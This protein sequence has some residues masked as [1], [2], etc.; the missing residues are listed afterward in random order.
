VNT[1]DGNDYQSTYDTLL[2]CPSI[3]SIYYEVKSQG[4][5]DPEQTLYGI[6]FYNDVTG[7]A[8]TSRN[9]RYILTETWQYTSPYI[10]QY[11]WWGGPVIPVSRDTIYTCYMSDSVPELFSASTSSLS[12]NILKHNS[13]NFVTNET[14]RLK[15]KYSLLVEQQSL[16]NE[17]FHY[18]DRMKS[19]SA[20]AGGLYESQPS[21]TT[22]TT[23]S[24]SV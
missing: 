7:T 3:D 6:Q 14:P 23:S 10:A 5:S 9:F 13:L 11:I 2:A 22:G 8:E 16:T 21:S 18:W 17:A 20:D 1:P 12:V 19:Q 4:T 15:T 24:V